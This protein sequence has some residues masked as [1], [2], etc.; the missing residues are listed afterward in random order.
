MQTGGHARNNEQI[1]T[2]REKEKEREWG[3]GDS[4]ESCV[5]ER[6]VFL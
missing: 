3:E 2:D 6:Q 4:K 1:G 5:S